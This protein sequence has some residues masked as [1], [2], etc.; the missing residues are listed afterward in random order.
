MNYLESVPKSLPHP[1]CQLRS[2]YEEKHGGKRRQSRGMETGSFAV[3]NEIL[4][5]KL[6][7]VLK[8][9]MVRCCWAS[10]PTAF[11]SQNTVAWRIRSSP[12]SLNCT[13][14]CR[15]RAPEDSATCWRWQGG[16]VAALA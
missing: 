16:T 15:I 7:H 11:T 13:R 3:S 8:I 6:P 10:Q 1:W 4:K 5:M 9:A 14:L 12:T 2:A